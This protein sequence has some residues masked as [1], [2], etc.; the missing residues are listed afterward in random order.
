MLNKI[1]DLERR[2]LEISY[3]NNL[4]HLS[5]SLT[6]V[7]IINEIYNLK[8]DDEPFILSCA[9]CFIGLATVLEFYY[10]YNAEM[11]SNKFGTHQSRDL[12][13]KIFCSGGSLGCGLGYALGMAMGSKN[14]V[15]CLISDGEC[16]EGTIFEAFRIKKKYNIDNLIIFCNINGYSALEEIDKKELVKELLIMCPNINIRYTSLDK[17]PFL[18]NI[19]AHYKKIT[20]EE[21]KSILV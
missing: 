21:Y 19:D 11:L 6:S 1:N 9:H 12:N 4:S 5:S 14:N 13:Y 15:Y 16:A 17:F 18:K 20:E 10:G 3:K 8:R 7:N 2:V